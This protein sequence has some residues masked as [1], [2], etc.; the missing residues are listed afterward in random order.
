MSVSNGNGLIDRAMKVSD[1]SIARY[2]L[3]KGD[4]VNTTNS[5][6]VVTVA[7]AETDKPIGITQEAT[8]AANGIVPVR[9]AGIGKLQVD[10]NAAA[11][12]IGDSICAGAAGV[13]HKATAPDADQQWAIGYALEPSA[14]DG[15]I[16]EVMIAPHLIVKGT[17]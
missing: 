3:V 16:I 17:A 9:L 12:D 4:T 14:A 15:D 5:E 8:T 13:G 7:T 2:K 10:G 6:K 1:A 11:I